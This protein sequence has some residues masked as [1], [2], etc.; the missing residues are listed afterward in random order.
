VKS[1]AVLPFVNQS[2]DPEQEYFADGLSQELI[3]ELAQIGGLDVIA[4]TSSFAFKGRNV[5]VREIGDQLGAG[6]V[7]EGTVRRSGDRLRIS[8]QIIDTSTGFEL[9]SKSYDR[10]L[11]DV[12]AIEKDVARS[13]AATLDIDIAARA[14]ADEYEYYGLATDS[15]Q[16]YD[17]ALRAQGLLAAGGRE[18]LLR[19]ETRLREALALDAQF[20]GALGLLHK[21]LGLIR[22]AV[23]ERSEQVGHEQ[24][25]LMARILAVDP[26]NAVSHVMRGVQ[27]WYANDLLEA[28]RAFERAREE[29]RPGEVLREAERLASVIERT[30]GRNSEALAQIR[31]ASRNDPLSL[32]TSLLLQIA[33][34]AGGRLEEVEQEYQRSFDLQG[35]R[36][37]V[38]AFAVMRAVVE[39]YDRAEIEERIRRLHSPAFAL[40]SEDFDLRAAVDGRDAGL[41]AVRRELARLPASNATP[42][43]FLAWWADHYEEPDLAL[44]AMRQWIDTTGVPD[45]TIWTPLFENTRRTR[46]FQNLLNDTGILAYWR[47]TGHWGDYCRPLDDRR[48]EC[49]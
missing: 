47:A 19:A 23:A 35:D 39:D 8:A 30:T 31:L 44:T 10:Q 28:E 16:A 33:L 41:A 34:H 21:T 36:S 11:G 15:A 45:P 32:D 38:E 25:E 4:R 46:G 43:V 24:H 40:S 37:Q 48:F 22:Y 5:D 20:L 42:R 7:L 6:H 26:D 18:D 17:L 2:A 1:I 9:W 12:L 13:V 14:G 29:A 27:H 3:N 49:R